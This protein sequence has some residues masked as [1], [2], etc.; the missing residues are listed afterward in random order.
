MEKYQNMMIL[1]VIQYYYRRYMENDETQLDQA[2]EE[3]LAAGLRCQ[4]LIA[5]RLAGWS[6]ISTIHPV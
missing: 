2:E 4:I 6:K 3:S 1:A 5:R